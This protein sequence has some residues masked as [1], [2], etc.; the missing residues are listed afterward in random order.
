M[1]AKGAAMKTTKVKQEPILVI[2]GAQN[3]Q[4]AAT[5]QI[6]SMT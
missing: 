2:W 5:N 6:W 3:N 1:S 4:V